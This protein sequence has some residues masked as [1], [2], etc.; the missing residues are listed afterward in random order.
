MDYS[1]GIHFETSIINMEEAQELTI[2]NKL[3]KRQQKRCRCG[4]IKLSRVTSK[5]FPVGLAIRKAKK[6]VLGMVLSKSEANK[7][8]ED[9]AE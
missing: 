6:K 4:S 3:V 9:V 5:D 7:A 8:A 1:Q 2:I